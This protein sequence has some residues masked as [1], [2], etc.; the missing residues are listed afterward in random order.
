[1]ATV[2]D[3]RY[4]PDGELIA[5]FT[6]TVSEAMPLKAEIYE[7]RKQVKAIALNEVPGVTIPIWGR[8]LAKFMLLITH[9]LVANQATDDA[10][11]NGTSGVQN[12][13]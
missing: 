4:G 11:E 7:T 5:Q 12:V 9:Y 2:T 13:G 10:P 8:V 6:R 3:E 1:M